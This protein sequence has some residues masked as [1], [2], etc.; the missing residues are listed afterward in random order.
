MLSLPHHCQ[1][2]S[3]GRWNSIDENFCL[4][5][6]MRTQKSL[7]MFVCLSS[8]I[9]TH[10]RTRLAFATNTDTSFICYRE[11]KTDKKGKKK[12]K[13]EKTNGR[14]KR[15]R[16]RSYVRLLCRV[17]PFCSLSRALLWRC[18]GCHGH[19]EHRRCSPFLASS[20]A[21]SSYNSSNSSNSSNND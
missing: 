21:G 12:K 18:V 13:K 1:F 17:R 14:I 6:Q 8:S 3:Y 7:L 11:K 5:K 2:D 10:V 20:S 9:Y 15:K 4:N 19:Q 16:R